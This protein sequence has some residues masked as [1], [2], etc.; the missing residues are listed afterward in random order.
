MNLG[1][2]T[3]VRVTITSSQGGS[4]MTRT[5]ITPLYKRKFSWVHMP[6]PFSLS[7]V[8]QSES[9]GLSRRED[10]LRQLEN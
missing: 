3:R 4:V 6:H 9:H 8:P 1:F 10:S 2:Q 7:P 5:A